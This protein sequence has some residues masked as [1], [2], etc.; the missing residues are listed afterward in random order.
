MNHTQQT[1]DDYYALLEVAPD[2]SLAEIKS[3]C[4]R[5]A[6]RYHLDRNPDDPEGAEHFKRITDNEPFGTALKNYLFDQYLRSHRRA[7]ALI[8]QQGSKTL[9]SE[10]TLRRDLRGARKHP[11]PITHAVLKTIAAF[12]NAEGGGLPAGIADDRFIVGIGSDAFDSEYTYMLHLS[13]VVGTALR[14]RA[15]TCIGP[16]MRVVRAKTICLVSCQRS[17]EPVFLRW[18]NAKEHPK[19]DF[20]VRSSPGR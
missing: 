20:Y 4:R 8:K 3:A 13:H 12:L 18:K 1:Q 7:E 14:D 9:E 2:A 11:K 10:S 16:K 15:P 19:G 17:P 5:L 6:M